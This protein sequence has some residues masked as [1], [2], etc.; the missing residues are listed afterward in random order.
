MSINIE[1]EKNR[2]ISSQEAYDVVQFAIAVAASDNVIDSFVFS[3]SLYIALA[4]VLY[5]E[6]KDEIS[7]HVEDGALQVWDMLLKDGTIDDMLTNYSSDCDFV[8]EVGNE[9]FED[10]CK[11]NDS[12]RG[13]IDALSTIISDSVSNLTGELKQITDSKELKQVLQLAAKLGIQP[14]ITPN[15]SKTKLVQ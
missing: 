8:A 2:T 14:D 3:R 15:E 9:M 6:R 13:I 12:F 1:M 4:L 7:A 5:P 11:Y 10:F